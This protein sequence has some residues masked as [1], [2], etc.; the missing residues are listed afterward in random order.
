MGDMVQKVHISSC[1]LEDSAIGNSNRMRISLG[2]AG[3]GGGA[4]PEDSD[5]DPGAEDAGKHGHFEP[6]ISQSLGGTEWV[7]TVKW[8]LEGI[9]SDLSSLSGLTRHWACFPHR[10]NEDD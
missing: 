7:I 8:V 9:R 1:F 3:P 4:G 6:P 10:E 2:A 5:G